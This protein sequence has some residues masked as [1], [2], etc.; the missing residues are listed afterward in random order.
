MNNEL[1]SLEGKV[2]VVTGGSR[3]FGKAIA[4]GFA[5]AGADVLFAPGL[6]SLE[7]VSLV[8]SS[9]N[10]P[11]SV[12]ASFMPGVT[13][14]ELQDAGAK[15]ISIGGAL[16]NAAIGSLLKAGTEMRHD[17]TFNWLSTAASRTDIARL[18]EK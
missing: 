18:L 10:K 2:A 4:L 13:L 11:V 12:L 14:T 3:G 9:V 17:G 1:F 16:A 5:D 7:Q 8:T 6:T 15:R